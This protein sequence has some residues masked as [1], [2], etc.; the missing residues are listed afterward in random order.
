MFLVDARLLGRQDAER[1]LVG[2]Y[3]A[4]RIS[5]VVALGERSEIPASRLPHLSVVRVT[6]HQP[7]LA[8][9]H[10]LGARVLLTEDPTLAHLGA[11]SR[12]LVVMVGS[13]RSY[14]PPYAHIQSWSTATY[15]LNR[16]ALGA[17]RRRS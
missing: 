2:L 3:R 5:A 1:S 6:P 9:A 10:A 13:A 17:Q 8:A 15:T 14:H 16:I 11:L 7:S 12:L 4:G